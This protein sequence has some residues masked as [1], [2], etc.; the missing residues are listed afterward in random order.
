[1]ILKRL[2]VAFVRFVVKKETREW[3]SL[4]NFNRQS[5][6]LNHELDTAIWL[7]FGRPD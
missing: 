3:R 7:S 5:R 1:M 2:F 4:M 6:W